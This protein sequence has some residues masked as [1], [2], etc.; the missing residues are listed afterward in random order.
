MQKEIQF[1]TSM[2]IDKRH[3]EFAYLRHNLFNSKSPGFY[4]SIDFQKL[5]L[6]ISTDMTIM[7]VLFYFDIPVL[8][9]QDGRDI[10]IYYLPI[11]NKVYTTHTSPG[12][13]PGHTISLLDGMLKGTLRRVTYECACIG[14]D[15]IRIVGDNNNI[16]KY[17]GGG[18]EF[19]VIGNYSGNPPNIA[20]F[21]G[22]Q[23]FYISNDKIYRQ[24]DDNAIV[25][26][27][28][29]LGYTP[30]FAAVFNN[31]I[32]IF[33]TKFMDIYILFWDKENSTLLQKTIIIKNAKLI[34]GGNINGKL[35]LV[36]GVGNS[37]NTKERDGEIIVAHFDG[38]KFNDIN[39]IKA[40]NYNVS[41]QSL[42]YNT[43]YTTTATSVDIGN[44][45]M[46]VAIDDNRESHNDELYKDWIL[47][48]HS[49]G[50]IET[51]HVPDT[52]YGN[53]HLVRIAYNYVL[54]GTSGNEHPPVILINNCGHNDYDDYQE[55]N[56]SRYITNFMNNPFNRHTLNGV[57]I[58]FEKMFEQNTEDRGE[59]LRIYYRTSERD[60]FTL[61]AEITSED[62][63]DYVDG[64][65]TQSEKD[66]YTSDSKSYPQQIYMINKL[67]DGEPLPEFNE[68]QFKFESQHGAS[69]IQAWYYY[70]YITRNTRN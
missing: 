21:D 54:L 50:S 69:I 45:I 26:A 51:L 13:N 70:D 16:Y 22:F 17:R 3:P 5:N 46:V 2:N 24:V 62:I 8:F 53:I 18:D 20:I 4:P 30:K 42:I 36:K 43:Y 9:I 61:L 10:K 39:S 29:G 7:N 28:S 1:H 37:A 32:V 66:R 27:F 60:T 35:T 25:E 38:E 23:Y 65:M 55:F 31:E 15:G 14:N 52:D 49:N 58:V 67:P 6:D 41:F 56:D 40:G 11:N 47:K 12:F 48:I 44:D 64:R 59:K 63:H 19:T 34:A 33:A 68:I 57:G